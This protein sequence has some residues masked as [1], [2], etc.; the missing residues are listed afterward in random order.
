MSETSSSKIYKYNKKA[1]YFQLDR[2]EPDHPFWKLATRKDLDPLMWFVTMAFHAKFTKGHEF[3]G[4]PEFREAWFPPQKGVG[5]KRKN[6][7]VD[8]LKKLGWITT[9]RQGNTQIVHLT[10]KAPVHF[11]E[12]KGSKI[13]VWRTEELEAALTSK[14][15]FKEFLMELWVYNKSYR[16]K[17]TNLEMRS[18]TFRAIPWVNKTSAERMLENLENKG[19]LLRTNKLHK[20]KD[21]AK[22]MRHLAQNHETLVSKACDT[23]DGKFTRVILLGAGVCSSAEYWEDVEMGQSGSESGTTGAQKWDVYYNGGLTI[24]DNPTKEIGETRDMTGSSNS[25]NAEEE[26]CSPPSATNNFISA[27]DSGSVPVSQKSLKGEQSEEEI[28]IPGKSKEGERLYPDIKREEEFARAKMLRTTESI[29]NKIHITRILT[30]HDQ[31]Q[32]L[33]LL[34]EFVFESLKHGH[35]VRPGDIG[36]QTHTAFCPECPDELPRYLQYLIDEEDWVFNTVTMAKRN[37]RAKAQLKEQALLYPESENLVRSVGAY[38]DGHYCLTEQRPVGLKME[39]AEPWA[40]ESAEHY[41]GLDQ[42]KIDQR[43]QLL[44]WSV[45]AEQHEWRDVQRLL[46]EWVENLTRDPIWNEVREYLRSRA[47]RIAQEALL[48]SLVE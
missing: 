48:E 20:L 26:D 21:H 29:M 12:P 37:E 45:L 11:G 16:D 28:G 25:L 18:M 47:C 41:L 33:N 36:S 40:L 9:R 44:A 43:P 7:K 5:R 10:D 27:S 46:S 17:S 23:S 32:T 22:T 13:F 3:K 1:T 15:K 24:R 34:R 2:M 42:R 14:P 35:K 39:L 8:V 38:I 30:D 31:E 6:Q 4:S 19:R